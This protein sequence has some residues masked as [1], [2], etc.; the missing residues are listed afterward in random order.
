MK[1]RCLMRE[2]RRQAPIISLPWEFSWSFRFF[3]GRRISLKELAL[4]L[5]ISFLAQ[6]HCRVLW[7]RRIL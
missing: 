2:W 1:Y 7:K 6:L 3:S 4:K 5:R